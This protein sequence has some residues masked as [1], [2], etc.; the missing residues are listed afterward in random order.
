[1][2]LYCD[3]HGQ[4]WAGSRARGVCLFRNGSCTFFTTREGLGHNYVVGF[5]EDRSGAIWVATLNGASRIQ[6]GR[7]TTWTTRDGLASNVIG[8]FH[9]TRTGS[10]WIGTQG[11]GLSRFKDGRFSN[12]STENGLFDDLAFQIVEDDNE[13]LWMSSNRGIY[14]VKLRELEECADHQR[15]TVTS[16]S[17]GVADGMLTRECNGAFPAGLRSADG[18]I[19]FG[20][21]KG[22]VAID[23]RRI[24]QG[25]PPQV[26]IEQVSVEGRATAPPSQDVHLA[27]NQ[28]SLEIKYT[29]LQCDRPQ[30][31]RFK[32]KLEGLDEDWKDA[33]VRRSVLYSYLPPG[34]YTFRVIADNGEGIWNMTGDR[35]NVSVANPYYRTWWFYSLCALLIAGITTAAWR[36]RVAGLIRAREVQR[37]FLRRLITSQEVERKRLAGELHD[38][39][40]QRL[41]IVK[42]FA[43]MLQ[44]RASPGTENGSVSAIAS[45]TSEALREVREISYALR[46]YQLDYLGLKDALRALIKKVQDSSETVF[47]YQLDDVNDLLLKDSQIHLYRIVQECLNNIVK[48]ARAACAEVTVTRDGNRVRLQIHDDGVGFTPEASGPTPAKAVSGSPAFP[49]ECSC[50]AET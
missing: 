36:A 49:S 14:R 12:V 7:V 20:T 30:Q 41:T 22:A 5:Y 17:Y 27:Q 48:H 25:R 9:Q 26:L 29:V 32:V 50:W 40:A 45:E 44:E 15:K 10:M 6:D 43:L 34:S 46:P 38:S 11:G 39:L 16:Y 1:M 19:W 28:H 33:G 18:R 24:V 8:C 13:N 47:T 23:P 42:N 21:S 4:L 35:L 37:Q 2:A 31:A 3:R